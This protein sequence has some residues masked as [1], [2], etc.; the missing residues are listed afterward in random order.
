MNTDLVRADP[1]TSVVVFCF[2]FL[3]EEV[4]V[5][6]VGHGLVAGVVGVEVV[7][8]VEGL[9][10][11]VGLGGVAAGFVEVD[12]G[13]E[14]SA[15][16]DEVVDGL[17]H[18]FALG[19][20]VVGSGEGSEGGAN[21]LDAA[22]VGS[23]DDLGVAPFDLLGGDGFVGVEGEEGAADVVGGE[24]EDEVA[25]TGLGEDV[26]IQACEGGG[27]G[28]VVEDAVAGDAFV[29]DSD[30]AGGEADGEIVGPP[31]VFVGGGVV[32]VG[33]GGSEDDDCGGC[34]AGVDVYGFE[35]GPGG[36]FG[37]SV[38]GGVAGGVAGDGE[39][40]GAGELVGGE[41][42]AGL[43]GDE[44]ADGEVGE[45]FDGERDWIADGVG[46]GGDGDGGCSA[47]GD[48]VVGVG[49][50]GGGAGAGAEGGVDVG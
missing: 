49:L 14:G 25:G 24:R 32:A 2:L 44:E 22:G 30:V 3:G 37:G 10:E 5:D 39:V 27:A 47:E 29:E 34:G 26:T 15:G 28:S 16:E 21:D 36:E 41:G 1:C 43:G 23:V 42:D 48:G 19:A 35:E 17:A 6:G 31:E 20:E 33:D 12:D 50:N 46:S 7:A 38:E 18:G 13:V 9:E 45:G 4:E 40:A 8:G 11:A